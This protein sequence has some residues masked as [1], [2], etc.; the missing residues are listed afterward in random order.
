MKPVAVLLAASV[1]LVSSASKAR[2]VRVI[3]PHAK[4]HLVAGKPRF[5]HAVDKVKRDL[6]AKA[7][8]NDIPPGTAP[9]G[10]FWDPAGFSRYI[11]IY[12]PSFT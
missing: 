9:M 5:F 6:R 4:S 1:A 12:C 7:Y 3:K 11:Y 2:L 10:K 8:P